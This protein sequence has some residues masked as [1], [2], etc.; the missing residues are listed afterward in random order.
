MKHL[1]LLL[2]FLI[3][4]F[5]LAGCA[6]LSMQASI[7]KQAAKLVDS[8]TAQPVTQPQPN[9][10]PEITLT[11]TQGAIIVDITPLNSSTARNSLNFN[12]SLNT[13]SIDLSMDLASLATL[14]TDDGRAVQA[15]LWE[16]PQGGHHVKGILSF[17]A[18][19][20]GKPLLSGANTVTL[21]ILDLDAPERI[22]TWDLQ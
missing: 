15:F 20:N 12:V 14:S 22:F 11:D 4:G 5:A 16:A 10:L 9:A 13:H 2:L 17:P 3:V 18:L 19:V 6:G 1:P 7:P 21:S 8:D